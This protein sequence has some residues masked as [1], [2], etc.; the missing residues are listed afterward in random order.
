[1]IGVKDMTDKVAMKK[2]LA[3]DLNKNCQL[4][5]TLLPS[6]NRRKN[7]IYENV[8][9]LCYQDFKLT[10]QVITTNSIKN[11]KKIFSILTNVV[12]QILAK[13]GTSIWCVENTKVQKLENTMIIGADVHHNTKQKGKQS[14]IGMLSSLDEKF[15]QYFRQVSFVNQGQELMTTIN[16]L[17]LK[18]VLRYKRENGQYPS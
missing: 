5:V 7:A 10:S 14:V 2:Q 6:F 18:A 11:E 4:I 16:E 13:N 15:T 3:Q 12:L 8:K 9:Q 17:V 1:M